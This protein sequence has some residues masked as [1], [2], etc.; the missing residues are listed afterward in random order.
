MEPFKKSTGKVIVHPAVIREV[1]QSTWENVSNILWKDNELSEAVIEKSKAFIKQY[2]ESIPAE[3]FSEYSTVYFLNFHECAEL[4]KKRAKENQK[5]I[6][7]PLI[8]LNPENPRGFRRT[9]LYLEV[10]K[11]VESKRRKQKRK[12]IKIVRLRRA[13]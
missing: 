12:Q 4:E 1:V 5:E 8:W 2:Y 10:I 13:S 9:S 6:P 7:S 11:K 3:E